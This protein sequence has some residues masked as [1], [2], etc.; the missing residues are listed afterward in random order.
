MNT[1]IIIFSK[2][3]ACQ[4]E[5]L[6]RSMKWGIKE[7]KDIVINILYT[8]TDGDFEIGYNKTISLHS[9]KNILWKKEINFRKN[10]IEMMDISKKYTIFFVDDNI[11]KSPFTFENERIKYFDKHDDIACLSLRLHPNLKY[12]YPAR[13]SQTPPKI[14]DNGVFSWLRQEGDYGYPMSL[15]GHLFKTEDI[16]PLLNILIY[17]N[18]NSLESNLASYPIRK[19]NMICFDKSVIFNNPI[20]KVQ[21]WNDNYHGSISAEFINKKYLSNQI[22]DLS[23]FINIDNISCH[24]EIDIK[25]IEK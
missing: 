3:R 5:L 16:L 2:N 9:D 22:I 24:Q 8:Y 13:I 25:F 6:L 19:P 4:L 11:F 10:L 15:D 20:N 23:T 14:N 7:F 18:P 21:T 1:N 12:C 17:D